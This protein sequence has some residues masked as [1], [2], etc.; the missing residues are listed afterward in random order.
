MHAWLVLHRKDERFPSGFEQIREEATSAGLISNEEVTQM[1]TLLDDPDFAFGS[2]IMFSAWG[3][4][5]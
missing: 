5:P 4:R 3:R 2:H 1:F